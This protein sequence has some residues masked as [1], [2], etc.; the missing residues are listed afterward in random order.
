MAGKT[1]KQARAEQD[2]SQ[3]LASDGRLSAPPGDRA[4]QR[5]YDQD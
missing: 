5:R 1:A 3:K 4:Q 2:A